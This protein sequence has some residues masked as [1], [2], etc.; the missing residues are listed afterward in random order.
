[1]KKKKKREQQKQEKENSLRR[2]TTTPYGRRFSCIAP[3]QVAQI[4]RCNQVDCQV[5]IWK[6]S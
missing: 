2:Q 6:S 5:R 3:Q 4:I 1:M